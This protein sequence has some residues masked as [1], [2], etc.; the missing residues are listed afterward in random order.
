M[1]KIVGCPILL[2][3]H[4]YVFDLRWKCLWFGLC[5]ERGGEKYHKKRVANEFH[6]RVLLE[7]GDVTSDEGG[8]VSTNA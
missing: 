4:D 1:E 8:R 7:G 2:E 5:D 3:N 6:R